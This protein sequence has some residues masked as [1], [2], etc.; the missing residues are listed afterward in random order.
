MDD[1]QMELV[2]SIAEKVLNKLCV[3]GKKS[4]KLEQVKT[5]LEKLEQKSKQMNI[6]SVFAV[7]GA[8]GNMIA[9]HVMDDA[10]LVSF[11]VAMKKAYTAVA[12]QMSTKELGVLAQPGGAL[13]GVDK[14]DNGR[15]IVFGGGVPLRLQGSLI[16]GLGV[17]GA[18]S[19]QDHELAVYGARILE[20]MLYG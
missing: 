18:T 19:E 9:I 11:D 16:G 10:Y 17:S 13:Y 8:D 4:L 15:L 14:A 5:L 12:V 6:R 7:C 2:E 20:D 3:E 1:R